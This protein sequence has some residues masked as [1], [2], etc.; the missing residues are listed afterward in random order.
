[1]IDIDDFKAIND[2]FGHPAGDEVL[3][4]VATRLRAGVRPLDAV[5]RYGGDEFLAVMPEAGITAAV[6]AGERIRLAISR[7]PIHFDQH[8]IPVTCSIGCTAS[9]DASSDDLNALIQRADRAL[10]QAKSSGR[11]RVEIEAALPGMV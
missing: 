1:V 10:Y 5:G 3:R 7:M 9:G 2:T 6:Q 11:S 8:E 4:V